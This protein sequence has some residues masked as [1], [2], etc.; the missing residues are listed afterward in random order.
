MASALTFTQTHINIILYT[1]IPSPRSTVS[2]WRSAPTSLTAVPASQMEA[3]CVAG[4]VWRTSAP[5]D[6]SVPT[7]PVLMVWGGSRQQTGASQWTLHWLWAFQEMRQPTQER[8]PALWVGFDWVGSRSVV[9]TYVR[10][11]ATVLT[12]LCD[13]QRTTL[14]VLVIR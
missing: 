14:L 6:H 13:E 9:R 2:Q 4:A 3:C 7:A 5:G 10:T 1:H 8:L 12:V 11:Y